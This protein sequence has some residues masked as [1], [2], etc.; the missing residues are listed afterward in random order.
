MQITKYLS[1]FFYLITMNIRKLIECYKL[2][3]NS[4]IYSKL[5]VL[6]KNYVFFRLTLNKPLNKALLVELY[7]GSTV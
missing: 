3:T 5:H 7:A 4:L 1:H 2:P 6:F